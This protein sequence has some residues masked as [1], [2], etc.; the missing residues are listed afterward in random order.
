MTIGTN[1]L[2]VKTYRNKV[3]LT[4]VVS[5]NILKQKFQNDGNS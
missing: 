4:D 1:N 5:W 2:D 3:E